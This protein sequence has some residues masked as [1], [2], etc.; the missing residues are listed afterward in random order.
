M[1]TLKTRQHEGNVIDFINTF[2]INQQRRDDSLK[3]IK[4]LENISGYKA[5][6]WGPTM[7]GFGSYHYQSSRS[8]QEGDWPLLGF[9]PRKAA[10]SLYVFTGLEEHAY[11]LDNLGN[12]RKGKACIYI[13][14][15]ADINLDVLKNISKATLDYLSTHYVINDVCR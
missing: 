2:C 12:F 6:M 1:A 9:S 5:K 7:I 4:I 14:K 11:L 15:L 8:R 13:K 10:I 3:L